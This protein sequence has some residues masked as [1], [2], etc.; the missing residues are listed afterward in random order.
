VDRETTPRTSR[1]NKMKR[2]L[3]F[4][5]VFVMCVVVPAAVAD[6]LELKNGSLV[7]GRFT[8]G[9]QN[10]INFQVG[11]SL[12]T[13]NV[14]DIRDLRFDAEPEG[15]DISS[16]EQPYS[17]SVSATET[18]KTSS[19]VTIPAGTIVSVRTID[20]IDSRENHV[21]DRFQASLEESLIVDDKVVAAKGADV[22]GR[23]EESKE[24]GTFTGRSE[25]KLALTGIV[26]DGK[27][28]PI[29]T[30]DYELTGKSKGASTAKRTFGG[31][32]IGGIIGA[33]AGGGEG[34]AIGA[35]TGAGVGA[36][37]EIITKGDQVKIPSETLLDFTLEQ[38]VSIP[39]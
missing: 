23:L 4:G 29:V 15:A 32:A 20:A 14:G 26:V 6:S 38:S 28:V 12:Q 19:Y 18:A 33:I 37:S 22:Y 13:Y 7:K 30:G 35:G 5:L 2:V 24:T 3:K 25:L 31:A 8:G 27:S 10:S 39:R 11:S 21:G 1:T 34:A 16:A 17:S 36:G 9:D